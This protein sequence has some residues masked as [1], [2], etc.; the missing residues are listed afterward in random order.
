MKFPCSKCGKCCE[1]IGVAVAAANHLFN[2]ESVKDRRV[3][4]GVLAMLGNLTRFP[5]KTNADGR[6][7]KLRKDGSCAI[8]AARPITC[9]YV[10]QFKKIF[11]NSITWAEYVRELKSKCKE[12]QEEK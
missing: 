12:L 1:V 8:Y 9:N 10:A 3:N 7:E 6:C 11:R 5:Y 4:S 2:E